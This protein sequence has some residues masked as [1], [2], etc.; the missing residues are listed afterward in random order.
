MFPIAIKK[1][2]QG[3]TLYIQVGFCHIAEIWHLDNKRMKQNIFEAKVSAKVG[4]QE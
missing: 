1:N 3:K 2:N 4:K